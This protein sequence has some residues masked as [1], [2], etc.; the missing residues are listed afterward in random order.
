MARAFDPAALTAEQCAAAVA[1]WAAIES[2]AA[3]AKSLAAARVA[4]TELWRRSGARSP[5]EDL[6]RRTGSS[7]TKAKEQLE[8]ARRVREQP[9]VDAAARAGTLSPEQT[10]AI[11]DAVAADPGAESRLVDGAGRQCLRELR[12]ECGRVK[13]A[14]TDPEARQRRLHRER[15]CRT[16]TDSDG[17]WNLHLRSTPDVGA[18]LSA[19]IQAEQDRIFTAARGDGDREPAEAY[20]HDAL[21]ALV[22]RDGGETVEP[23]RVAA[24]NAKVVVRVDWDALVRGFPAGG[25]VCEVVGVGPVPVSTVEAILA[26]GDAF[27]AAVVTRGGEV[28]GVV[29]LG[30]KPTERQVTALQWRDPVCEVA[31]CGQQRWFEIDHRWDWAESKVTLLELLDRLCRHHHALKTRRGW[32]LVHG[33]GKRAMVPPDDPS[34]PRFAQVARAG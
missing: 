5:E 10:A 13:A 28:S 16:Y 12:D 17:A 20:A 7:V 14:A 4:E 24:R 11:S 18:A 3:H 2:M 25:E 19:R 29:H 30:R 26:T 1:S 9:A 21:V 6:A 27:L 8:T 34:H 15:R 22:L 33:R 32:A 31:G 23:A